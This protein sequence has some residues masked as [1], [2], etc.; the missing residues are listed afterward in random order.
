MVTKMK[1]RNFTTIVAKKRTLDEMLQPG[2]K[3]KVFYSERNPNNQI[4]HIR[5]IVDNEFIAYRVW[6]KRKR[7]WMYNIQHRYN[8]ELGY[9]RGVL[10]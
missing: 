1:N 4:R 2:Q 8:F 10:S 5:A 3:I 6:S 7:L 9:E